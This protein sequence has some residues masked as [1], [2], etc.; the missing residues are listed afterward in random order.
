MLHY[1]INAVG[2]HPQAHFESSTKRINP[3]QENLT[4]A[5]HLPR[6]GFPQRLVFDSSGSRGFLSTRKHRCRPAGAPSHPSGND[7]KL[8]QA[9]EQRGRKERLWQRPRKTTQGSGTP[10]WTHAFQHVPK[11]SHGTCFVLVH[12]ILQMNLLLFFLIYLLWQW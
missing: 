8:Q 11:K 12:N 10:L 4:P 1:V 5:G 7:S 6:S 9:R 2:T 3:Q